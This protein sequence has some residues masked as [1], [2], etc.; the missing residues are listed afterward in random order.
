MADE[1]S[2]LGMALPKPGP[3]LRVVL[4]LLAAVSVVSAIVVHWLPGGPKGAELVGYLTFDPTN[5]AFFLEPWRLLTSGLLTSPEGISHTLFTLLGL[6][7]LGGD[8]ERRWGGG[9]FVGLL[10]SSVLVG[11]LLAF[12]L[13]L[14]Q[15]G[16]KAGPD[17]QVSADPK[18]ARFGNGLCGVI[19]PK[20]FYRS[21]R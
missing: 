17:A 20:Q 16:G 1:P 10:V 2:S 6:Y 18:T 3:T 12:V 9:R 14:D 11:N 8:L 7:F 4:V 13:A 21:G 15:G 5:R 19:D